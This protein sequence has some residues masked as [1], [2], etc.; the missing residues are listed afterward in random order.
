M[1]LDHAHASP[2]A[3]KRRH[4]DT[5]EHSLYHRREEPEKAR[6]RL[7][8]TPGKENAN[9]V[10]EGSSSRHGMISMQDPTHFWEDV[11]GVAS[12]DSDEDP[13]AR[14]ETQKS[15]EI[16]S[17]GAALTGNVYKMHPMDLV[18]AACHDGKPA[19]LLTIP[20]HKEAKPFMTVQC[21]RATAMALASQR[22]RF[23]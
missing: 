21:S 9:D 10:I 3:R 11:G 8:N 17:M 20:V 14:G 23:M 2:T 18:R 6:P 5:F 22:P 12:S 4:S 16:L 15:S 1:G 7:T 19:I 13:S